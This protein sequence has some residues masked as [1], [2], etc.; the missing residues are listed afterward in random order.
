LTINNPGNAP[1]KLI[2]HFIPEYT[3]AQLAEVWGAVRSQGN[4]T[5]WG[6]SFASVE[7]E[8]WTH[9]SEATDVSDSE[10]SGNTQ[11]RIGFTNGADVWTKQLWKTY[12]PD[13]IESL[14]GRYDLWAAC[15]VLVDDNKTHTQFVYDIQAKYALGHIT[16]ATQLC[17]P[18]RIN[19]APMLDGDD[20]FPIKI[21]TV[22]FDTIGSI[23]YHELYVKCN[24]TDGALRFDKFWHAPADEDTFTAWEPAVRGGGILEQWTTPELVIPLDAT[25]PSTGADGSLNPDTGA[26]FGNIP[27]LAAGYTNEG[28][29]NPPNAGVELDPG[30]HRVWMVPKLQDNKVEQSELAELRLRN[31]TT[32]ND[33]VVFDFISGVNQYTVKRGSLQFTIDPGDTDNYQFQLVMTAQRDPATGAAVKKVFPG[34]LF[35]SFIRALTD[36]EELIVDGVRRVAYARDADGFT[37]HRWRCPNFIE[38]PPGTSLIMFWFGQVPFMGWDTADVRGPLMGFDAGG[39]FRIVIDL[40]PFV[41][42]DM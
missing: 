42:P 19:T 25:R 1:G 26:V 5:E 3:L 32:Q 28:K 31:I 7:A 16:P 13:D 12:E 6:A 29:G 17:D 4:L 23:L 14:P 18:I 41:K 36:G 24:R 37:T 39:K 38:A 35:H 22:T 34:T 33:D 27:V 8:D 20:W 10:C 2:L 9:G 30:V 40:V 21:G 15:K 11:V